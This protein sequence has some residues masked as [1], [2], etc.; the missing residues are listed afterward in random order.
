[1]IPLLAIDGFF[2]NQNSP[3]KAVGKLYF[4]KNSS[5]INLEPLVSPEVIS[6]SL[7]KQILVDQ[8]E[9]DALPAYG[10]DAV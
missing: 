2:F 1:M 6:F 4:V 7:P 10:I 5:K 9:I 8:F 3:I